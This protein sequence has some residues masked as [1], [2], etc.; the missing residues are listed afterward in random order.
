MN[1]DGPITFTG[2]IKFLQYI[3]G[4]DHW[5]YVGETGEPAFA[6]S[7]VNYDIDN[8][9]DARFMKDATGV[10]HIQGMIKDGTISASLPAFV[11]PAGYRPIDDLIYA[12]AS[13]NAFGRI[14]VLAN[15][16]VLAVVGNNAW[17]SVGC[18]F[19]VG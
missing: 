6:N 3:K 1:T 13:N 19:Y 5:H 7:W 8:W 11:L 16:Y 17:F 4:P 2:L 18:S 14:S 9:A 12:T 10:V 15:G